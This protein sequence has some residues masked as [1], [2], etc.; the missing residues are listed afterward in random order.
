MVPSNLSIFF[1]YIRCY[2]VFFFSVF[3]IMKLQLLDIFLTKY[4]GPKH[5]FR[6]LIAPSLT[7]NY[8]PY[9]YNYTLTL[10]FY[11]NYPFT[12]K[13]LQI[14]FVYLALHPNNSTPDNFSLSQKQTQVAPPTSN[15]NI[16]PLQ[17]LSPKNHRIPDS[18][19]RK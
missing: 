1:F 13:L 10:K 3:F 4:I 14:F 19:Q 11:T 16:H 6:S 8:T 5:L 9:P 15:N 7:G 2:Y 18:S 12:L 17:K